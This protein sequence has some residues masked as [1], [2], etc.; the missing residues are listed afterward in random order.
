MALVEDGRLQLDDSI[1]G[2]LPELPAAW[3]PITIRH[4]LSHTSGLPDGVTPD[5][6][7][8]IPLAGD[9]ES[10]LKIL[11]SVPVGEP[12]AKALQ[13]DRADAVGRYR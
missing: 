5:Q 7:N 2:Y 4:C 8:I 11:G 3:A 1:R 6:V 13:S 12:G 9:R 10:L